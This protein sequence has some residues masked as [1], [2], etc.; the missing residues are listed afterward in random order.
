MISFL[1]HAVIN[2]LFIATKQAQSNFIPQP[3]GD[4]TLQKAPLDHYLTD[5]SR[6]TLVSCRN[7]TNNLPVTSPES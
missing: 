6:L 1:K 3:S 2:F 4:V 7:W 5:P